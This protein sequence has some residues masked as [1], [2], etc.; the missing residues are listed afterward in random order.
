MQAPLP[1]KPIGHSY[2]SPGLLS[3]I[4]MAKLAEHLPLYRQAEIYA[5]Q[6]VELSR[7]TM[8][9]WVDTMGEQLRPLYDELNYYVLMPGKVHADDTPVNVLEPG[10]GK[11]RTGGCRSM[12]VT[13]ATP[14]RPCRLPC[15]SPTLQTAKVST[16]SDIWRTTAVSCR[17][18]RTRVITP[19]MKVD[20]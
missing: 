1:P 6:G 15:G 19:S 9:H 13:I 2:A 7:N 17:P 10:Q 8:G 12:F 4:I 3:R 11:T 20:G 14:V 5:R 18:M 16:R